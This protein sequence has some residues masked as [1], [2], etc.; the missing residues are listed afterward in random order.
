[1][2]WT[3]DRRDLLKSLAGGA[4]LMAGM[5]SLAGAKELAEAKDKV[6]RGSAPVKITDVR[7][8]LT[9]PGGE[10]LVIVKVET[11]EPGLYGVGCATHGERPLAV[12]AVVDEYLKPLLV[13]KSVEDIEDIWQTQYIASYFRSGV[14][15]NNALSGVDGA[16]WDI[17][18]KR[19]GM[20]VYKLLGGKVR[21]A[22]TLYTHA[23][24][25]TLPELEDQVRK[26]MAEGYRHVRVQLAVPGFSGYGV[27]NPTSDEVQ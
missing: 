13:G 25:R 7:T 16:L 27:S 26:Y 2:N 8:I 22:V 19:A 12:R 18:G 23:S 10:W 11:S 1:M 24:A 21:A 14:T 17:L 6:R 20:P 5:S 4:G 15:L 3:V 9:Q